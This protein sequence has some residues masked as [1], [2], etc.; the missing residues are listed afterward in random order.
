MGH[1]FE[2]DFDNLR[3]ADAPP[4]PES[5]ETTICADDASEELPR[6]STDAPPFPFP[7]HFKSLRGGCY[8]IHYTPAP[9]TAFFWYE[10]TLR[11]EKP[12]FSSTIASGDLY[13]RQIL[14]PPIVIDPG[15]PLIVDP[16]PPVSGPVV[17]LVAP[18]GDAPSGIPIYPRSSY[19]YYLRVTKILQGITQ[20]SSFDLEL[21]RHRFN[22][23][24]RTWTNEGKFTARMVW[25]PAPAG[26]PSPA[27]FLTGDVKNAA[28]TIVAKLSMGWVSS[29]LRRATVEIDRVAV[30]EAPLHNGAGIGWKTVFDQVGWD[31]T[32]VN[33]Q[34]DVAEPSGA[35]WSNAEMHAA[36]L[37]KR[38]ASNLDAEWRYHILA[39]REIDSTPRGIMY[40]SGA[41]DSN[42]VPREAVG[43]SS[44][45]VIPNAD[46]W[47][48]VK[49]MR[50][51]TASKPYFRTAIHEIG[52]AM[53]LYH[54]TVDNGFL[55]TTDV[56]AAAAVPPQQF[57]D[58]IKWSHASDDQRRL[59]HFPDI[60][61]RPGGTPF[62]TPYGS[63]PITDEA[64]SPAGLEL[65][66]TPL[67]ASVPI[68]AP[69]RVNFALEN[70]GKVD[71]VVPARLSM[72]AGAIHGCVV[73]PAGTVRRFS[74]LVHFVDAE[75]LELLAPGEA[76]QHA[77]TLLR[78]PQGAL[79]AAPGLYRIVLK[80]EWHAGGTAFEVEGE[81]NVMVTGAVDTDHAETAVKVLSSPDALLVLVLGGDHLTDG[82]EAIQAALANPVLRPY[83]AVTEAR[84]VG[85]RFGKRKPNA[86]AVVELIDDS[87]EMTGAEI[88]RL[89]EIAKD[90][91]KELATPAGK[92][93]VKVLQK[94]AD[95]LAA[96][97]S[98]RQALND[99]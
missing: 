93:F 41:T 29:Y 62:G 86:K 39:V 25:S 44:H 2:V 23:A 1:L 6:R 48:L 45:W 87:T 34:A 28:G 67:A 13:R 73:D 49:G 90:V 30:S 83:F 19:T 91:A 65:R 78:G 71:A 9:T 61:V 97:D 47:G 95:E 15:P 3:V 88:T 32:L 94:K 82:I 31:I 17:P 22:H 85:K 20:G 74:P 18:A 43:I 21:E 96:D 56:I 89:A 58:N 55:N 8:R 75:P 50:F 27:D 4:L 14:F 53:G 59:R 72:K 42:N 36:M 98:V 16:R 51:G 66:V 64:V 60:H 10:G 99:L 11:V 84:R 5:V 38:N 76:R 54:N 40:D 37:V 57:P 81:T 12:S 26:Y 77:V 52:H 70:A 68:G 7:G 92:R 33:S 79:F 80:C 69:V 46:P 63:T 35:G 24:N